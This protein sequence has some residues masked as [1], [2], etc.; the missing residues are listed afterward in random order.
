MS[1]P[2]RRIYARPRSFEVECP[3]CARLHVIVKPHQSTRRWDHKRSELDCSCGGFWIVGLSLWRGRRGR[4]D[5]RRRPEDQ[6]PSRATV[7]ALAGLQEL[8]GV[9]AGK[10][11]GRGRMARSLVVIEREGVCSCKFLTAPL[12][13]IKVKGS[14]EGCAIHGDK[15]E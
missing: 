12:Q 13:H 5:K 10:A 2:A 4:S 3:D 9:V 14:A 7:K 1:E 8:A 6:I 11:P 15:G